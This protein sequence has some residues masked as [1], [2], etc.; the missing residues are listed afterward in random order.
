MAQSKSSR[1]IRG[2]FFF[3]HD[4]LKASE[5]KI[6]W[7]VMNKRE[8]AF[9]LLLALEFNKNQDCVVCGETFAFREF[10]LLANGLDDFLFPKMTYICRPIKVTIR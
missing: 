3:A 10:S 2:G 8:I 5:Y 6:Q 7:R 9:Y 1:G 4:I